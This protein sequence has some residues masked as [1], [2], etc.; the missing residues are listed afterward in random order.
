MGT[1]AITGSASG[2]GAATRSRLEQA[3][4]TVIGVDLAGQ[5][6]EA[7]LSSEEGRVHAIGEIEGAYDGRLDGL[8]P[9]AGVGPPADPSLTVSVNY[10]GAE[11]LLTGLRPALAASGAAQVVALCSNSMSITPNVPAEIIDACV[12]GDEARA[13]D[14]ASTSVS[15]YAY[16]ASKI[17]LARYVRRNA[18]TD[19]WAGSG[20][21]L[22]AVAP[23]A[24]MTPLA[25]SG[26]DSDEVGEAMRTLPIPTGGY[27]RPEQIAGCIDYLLTGEGSD[28]M[29][30]SIVYID[31][32]SDT[33]IRPDAVPSLFEL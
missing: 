1:F 24:T 31:G 26:L 27:A 6:I 14:L 28:F 33:A 10:F 7:D 16:A 4:H 3:G 8:V 2:I 13:R 25:Q 17:A 32:G 20:I 18:A 30:G 15:A 5:E 19:A 12:D 23:G 29:C 11:A 22:N 9:A 21:R